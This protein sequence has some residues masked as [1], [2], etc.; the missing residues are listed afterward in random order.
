MNEEIQGLYRAIGHAHTRIAALESMLMMFL[1][2]QS[3]RD[4]KIADLLRE[5]AAGEVPDV[6]P[7]L[8]VIPPGL[9]ESQ[10][11][12]IEANL[13]QQRKATRQYMSQL[14]NMFAEH[15]KRQK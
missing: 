1:G 2:S 3:K 7:D 11:A 13:E 12:Q 8:S 10:R 5:M 4:P 9:S 15:I 14:A 6:E